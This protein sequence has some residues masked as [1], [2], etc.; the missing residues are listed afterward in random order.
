[1]NDKIVVFGQSCSG[2]TTFAKTLTNHKYYCF[3]A[4]FQWHQI[5]G[6][7]LSIEDNLKHIQTVCTADQYV[8]DGWSLGDSQ[9]KWLPFN[10]V[11][12]VVYCSYE[13]ILAQYRIPVTHIDEFKGMYKRWYQDIDYQSLKAKYIRNQKDFVETSFN[14]FI[15][16]VQNL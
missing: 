13:Q 6:L 12:Y 10:S 4:L 3:D 9:G 1:M 11:V 2:K 15:A 8:L 7:G 16:V 5:E 14:E